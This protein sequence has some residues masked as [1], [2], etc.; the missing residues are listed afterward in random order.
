MKFYQH[1]PTFT[2]LCCQIAGTNH[3]FVSTKRRRNGLRAVPCGFQLLLGQLYGV[4]RPETSCRVCIMIFL[5]FID[6]FLLVLH[7]CKFYHMLIF[8]ICWNNE[9]I[10]CGFYPRIN[11]PQLRFKF[12]IKK[13]SY[14][15]FFKWLPNAWLMGWR[16]NWIYHIS[17]YIHIFI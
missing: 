14:L 4:H 8:M 5:W 16:A 11:H 10:S 7:G 6:G 2:H 15:G 12:V 1:L 13:N 9:T 3:H 17:V